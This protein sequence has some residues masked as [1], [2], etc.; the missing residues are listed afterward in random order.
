MRLTLS[1]LEALG[2]MPVS[3]RCKMGGIGYGYQLPTEC[4]K[5]GASLGNIVWVSRG[6]GHYPEE[7]AEVLPV[8]EYID[9][10]RA[11]GTK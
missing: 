3:F 5:A 2:A 9:A 4:L 7:M 8:N 1:Q 10:V 11:M 6:N